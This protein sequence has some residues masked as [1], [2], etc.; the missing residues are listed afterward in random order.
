[1]PSKASYGLVA[2]ATAALAGTSSQDLPVTATVVNGCLIKGPSDD[3]LVSVACN[4]ILSGSL[5]RHEPPHTTQWDHTPGTDVVV[6]TV[7]F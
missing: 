3:G 5:H 1:M 7:T 4:S 6:V 2:F